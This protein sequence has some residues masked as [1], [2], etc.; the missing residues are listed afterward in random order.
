MKKLRIQTVKCTE[1][2][3]VSNGRVLTVT[4]TLLSLCTALVYNHFRFHSLMPRDRV[5]LGEAPLRSH[6]PSWQLLFSINLDQGQGELLCQILSPPCLN[7][8]NGDGMP[9]LSGLEIRL[10]KSP[11]AF[12]PL[13]LSPVLLLGS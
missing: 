5:I 12:R 13:L 10:G 7:E 3:L 9:R 1:T 8:P 4:P 11:V 6:L 2:P